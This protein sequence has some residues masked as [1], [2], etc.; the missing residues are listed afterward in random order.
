MGV[1]ADND[2]VL[3]FPPEHVGTINQR[4]EKNWSAVASGMQAVV[5]GARGTGRGIGLDSTYR[6]AGKT[7]TAQV[8]GLDVGEEY[9]EAAVPVHLRHH[10][11]FIAY[12][13]ADDPRIAVAVVA[14]HGGAGSRVA[15][16]IA[17]EILDEWLLREGG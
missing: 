14:E 17:R 9:E 1:G 3:L 5:H 10:A 8:F 4:S 15:A 13:P 6:I 2:Q 16:P 11:L 12:A 7:G